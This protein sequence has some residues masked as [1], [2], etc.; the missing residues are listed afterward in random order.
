MLLVGF[1]PDEEGN[2][3]SLVAEGR[4]GGV[5]LFRRN[6]EDAVDVARISAALRE[7]AKRGEASVPLLAVDQ[8]Q[9]RVCRIQ[10]GVTLFPGAAAL[11]KRDRLSTTEGVAR[12]VGRE[13]AALGV[14]L[15]LAPVADVVRADPPPPVLVDRAF[16]ADPRQ[17]A[18]HVRAWVRGS[19]DGG[20]AACAKHFP[21]H[22]GV[23]ADSHNRLPRDPAS[24]PVLKKFHLVP[25]AAAIRVRVAAVMVGHVAYDALD[26]GVPASLSPHVMGLLRRGMRY[27]GLVL[28]DDL[29]MGAVS[30]ASGPVEAAVRAIAA[31]ADMALVG[32]NMK[33]E[34]EAEELVRGVEAAIADGRLSEERMASAIRRVLTFKRWWVPSFWVPPSHHSAFPRAARLARRLWEEGPG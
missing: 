22:G 12:W 29:E 18:R 21:G 7:A 10:R 24:L 15:N 33:A 2:I 23:E 20:V 26:P 14:H 34:V 9:G 5:I 4:L 31:G 17:V 28:T 32:R 25:F 27:G 1:R 6:A 3:L 8:E 13:L 19:Q 16:G 30:E 11:G